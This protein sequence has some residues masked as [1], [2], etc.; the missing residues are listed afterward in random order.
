MKIC[1][2]LPIYLHFSPGSRK[3]GLIDKVRRGYQKSVKFAKCFYIF[4]RL[5][6]IFKKKLRKN[7]QKTF[8]VVRFLFCFANYCV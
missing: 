4:E 7:M 3:C 6:Q 1:Q 5:L 8:I 2:F